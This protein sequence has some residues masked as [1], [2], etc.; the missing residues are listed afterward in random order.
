MKSKLIHL[1]LIMVLLSACDKVPP[2]PEKVNDPVSATLLLPA[3]NEPCTTGLII[4]DTENTV[5][6]TWNK[7]DFTD[8]YDLVLKNLESSTMT[9]L[10]VKTTTAK[11]NLQR[12][13]PYS[14]QIISKSAKS[15]ETSKSEIWKFYN[16]GPTSV[17]YAPY[18]AE[19]LT[20]VMNANINAATGKITLTWNGSDA[21][22]DIKSYDVYFGT[23]TTPVFLAN[24]TTPTL[25][26][27]AIVAKKTYYWRVVTKDAK[28]NSSSSGIYQFNVE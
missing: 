28:G 16:A 27:V 7:S 1:V 14:W 24:V 5:T 18:P 25:T 3:K 9:T 15:K 17:T 13:A 19:I 4:S 2:T 20:P 22:N 6:F 26:D 8:S 12:N 11:I 23:S 21:D 10:N